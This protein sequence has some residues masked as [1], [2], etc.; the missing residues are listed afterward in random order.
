MLIIMINNKSWVER[1]LY[2]ILALLI[3]SVLYRQIDLLSYIEWADESETIVV[4]KMLAAGKRLYSDIFNQHGPMVFIPGYFISLL[5]SFPVEVYRI[6]VLLLQIVALYSI[7]TSPIVPKNL[8][9]LYCAI[10]GAVMVLYLPD[11]FGHMYKYQ[12]LA[13]LF[14]LI[15][16]MVYVL[17]ML[18]GVRELCGKRVILG[19]FLLGSLPFL[20]I[21]FIPFSTLMLI[22][23]FNK[24]DFCK[25]LI[26]LSIALIINLAFMF[27]KGYFVGYYAYH[28]YLNTVIYPMFNQSSSIIS[29]VFSI[30]HSFTDNYLGFIFFVLLVVGVA[31]RTSKS[32]SNNLK[33]LLFILAASS[34]LTRGLGFHALPFYYLVLSLP[35]LYF[36]D[37]S[38]RISGWQSFFII[39]FCVILIYKLMAIDDSD[40]KALIGRKIPN[41]TEFSNLVKELTDPEDKIIS[42]S[43]RN[44]EYLVSNRLPASG[45]FFYL[46]MQYEYNKHPYGKAFIDPCAD[47]ISNKPKVML[48]DKWKVWDQYEWDSYSGCLD[49]VISNLYIKVKDRP[50]YILESS[51]AEA[52][53]LGIEF[54]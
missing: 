4:T 21:S 2:L 5:G 40:K 41:S 10:A 13:G 6:P 28:V 7:F 36:W 44:Y 24:R 8:R 35:A 26:G 38:I 30:Y 16:L 23:V 52:I 37:N 18:F 50:Y 15:A 42:Y 29:M 54:E 19:S 25:I 27:F 33:W 49:T 32:L 9:L 46:P 11:L 31:L 34:L 51:K 53:K 39:V 47:I 17:P 1:F 43:F 14:I 12:V 22:I 20:A 48:I 3:F 45:Y